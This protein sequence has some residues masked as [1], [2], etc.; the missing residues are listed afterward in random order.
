MR[1]AIVTLALALCA[2]LAAAD[3]KPTETKPPETQPAETKPAETKP[4]E[5]KPA[6]TK[7]PEAKAPPVKRPPDR[8]VP[9]YDGRGGEPTTAL[10]VVLWIPRIV[11]FP[12]RL[13]VDY[14]VRR[15]I[16]F[17]V[18]KAEHSKSFR[19]FVANLFREVENANPLIYPVVLVDFG[20]K[21]SVGVRAIWRRGYLVPKSDVTLRAG[22]GG[23]D[24]WR[25]D[26]GIKS[27]IEALR[28]TAIVGANDRPDYVFYGIGRDTPPEA[29]A[30]YASRRLFARGSVGGHVQGIGD[31][32]L[33]FG[34]GDNELTSS[35]YSGDPSIEEQVAAGRIAALPI[36]YE[37][38]YKTARIGTRITL[39]SRFDGKRARSGVRFDGAVERV[40]DLTEDTQWTRVE[41]ML[42]AGLLLDPVHERKLDVRLGFE[43]VEP[44][45]DS[46]QIPFLELA[47]IS[48][49]PWLRGL[50]AGRLYGST[51]AAFLV[52]YH[53]PLAA[54]LDAH[55]H[56]GAGNV[57]DSELS[58]FALRH[59]RGSFG[60]ALTI[61]GLTERQI[62]VSLH[63]GTEP[64]GDGFDVSS[65]RIVLEYSSDY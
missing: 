50:P 53:W 11:L 25:A 29:K 41:L 2:P 54:W 10:D 48:G 3:D 15:P 39:D 12:V 57:F 65:T 9:D 59:L 62:G 20:F 35:T 4:A 32:L 14:G 19:K 42:G 34:I 33:T 47:T 21:P 38:D 60:G 49:A 52:D 26:L 27:K 5:T 51:A 17:V 1:G 56:L 46:T 28:T 55:A 37:S 63:F 16:G 31:A 58:G 18:R 7:P 45:D 36:G 61:A 43:L 6:E 64:L 44:D 23:T 30:R 24:Y 22:T 8:A 40:L 13:V